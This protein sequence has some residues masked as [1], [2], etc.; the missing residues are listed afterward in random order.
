MVKYRNAMQ[1]LLIIIKHQIKNNVINRICHVLLAIDS[2]ESYF[3]KGLNEL[4]MLCKVFL[5]VI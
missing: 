4:K 3:E 2:A 5:N 1:A